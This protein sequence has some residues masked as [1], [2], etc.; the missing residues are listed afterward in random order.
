MSL[1]KTLSAL[2]LS[3]PLACSGG[4]PVIDLRGDEVIVPDDSPVMRWDHLPHGYHWT[5]KAMNFVQFGVGQPL[6]EI[7]PRDIAAWCPTYPE[8]NAKMRAAFWVG[9]LSAMAKHESTWNPKAVGGGGQWFG[10]VQISP[11][12]ARGYDCLAISGEAL[13]DGV[14]NLSCA[15]RI[16]AHTVPRDGVVA[17]GMRGVAADWGPFHSASKRAE[18]AAWTTQQ[19]YCR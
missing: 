13:K 16:M 7:V 2:L 8:N 4:N 12:T 18:M 14:S 5:D 10:L 15:I 11:A 9:L 19:S 3:L 6:T 17:E 1:S